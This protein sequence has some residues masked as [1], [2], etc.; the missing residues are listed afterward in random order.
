MAALVE[1]KPFLPEHGALFL[2]YQSHRRAHSELAHSGFAPH[3]IWSDLL[4]YRWAILEELF[5]LFATSHGVTHLALTPFGPGPIEPATVKAFEQM[6]RMNPA[7]VPSRIDNVDE[8]SALLLGKAGFSVAQASPDYQYLREEIVN[9]FGRRFHSQR[10]SVRRAARFHP[11]LRPFSRMDTADC[12]A[13]F[14]QW[15]SNPI[16]DSVNQMMREDARFA[17]DAA[18]SG[19]SELGLTGRIVEVEKQIVGYTFGFPLSQ[20]TF[21]V[22]LEIT[23]RSV[24]GLS[25]WLFREFCRELS[26]YTFINAMDDS[27]L[28]SLSRAKALWR[29]VRMI[30]SYTVTMA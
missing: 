6:S 1:L 10:S 11:T 19:Y 13:V 30:P 24:H 21:C 23:N 26:A 16:A 18:M 27:G 12:L 9:L 25:A 4:E 20:K 5:C 8:S 28:A 29:P 14:D 17:H 2:E 3:L 22:L 15:T 7:H